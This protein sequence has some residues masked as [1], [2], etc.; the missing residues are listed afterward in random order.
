MCDACGRL[1][2]VVRSDRFRN[3][4]KFRQISPNLGEFGGKWLFYAN[5]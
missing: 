1:D 2:R 3:F 4:A 5:R